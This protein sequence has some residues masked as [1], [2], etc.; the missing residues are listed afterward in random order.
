MTNQ[1]FI[2]LIT[3]LLVVGCT[4]NERTSED[5]SQK[6]TINVN[7]GNEPPTLDWSL[8]MD[9]TSYTILNN[10]ME[11]LTKFDETLIPQPALAESWEISEDG[12]TY[13]F[14]IR[15]N[16]QWSDGKPLKAEDF[17]YSWKRILNP[18]TG[19][20]YAYFLYDIENAEEYN[21]G[22]IDDPD[23]VGVKALDDNTL[24]VKLRRQASYFPSLL[25]F[26]S[27]FP[28]RKDVVERHGIKWTE[29]ENIVTLGPYKLSSW[30]HHSHMRL[31]TNPNYWG[32]KPNIENVT[33]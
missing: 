20:H 7:I 1:L 29:P 11:G 16:V 31:K 26:M 18:A 17:E 30:R 19:G 14:K 10:L 5:G 27:T 33:W 15:E 6:N 3:A 2:I 23:K 12:T 8:A 13:T 28:M 24:Q 22:K 9:S 21:T 25:V 4:T 32:E